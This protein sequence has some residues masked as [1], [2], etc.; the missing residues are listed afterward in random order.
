MCSH[1]R[2]SIN[3]IEPTPI[4]QARAGIGH[5]YKGGEKE[6]ERIDKA[7]ALNTKA[8]LESA[9]W[10]RFQIMGFNYQ[11]AGFAAVETFINAMFE[12]EASSFGRLY[13]FLASHR[14]GHAFAGTA[15]G[16]LRQ[17]LQRCGIRSE[18]V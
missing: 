17:R 2:H 3:T 4:F 18:S 13:Q 12:S 1:V 10:G 11:N 7:M 15:L 16:R 8:A 14:S 5:L 9:S 6:Y